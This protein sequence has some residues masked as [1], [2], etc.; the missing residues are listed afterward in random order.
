VIFLCRS[1]IGNATVVAALFVCA[2]SVSGTTLVI[3]EMN[4]PFAG[5]MKVS[6]APM[7]EALSALGQ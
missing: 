2:P 3:L 5:L 6:S 1:R 7:R 4:T